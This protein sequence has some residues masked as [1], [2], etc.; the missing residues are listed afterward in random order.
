[1]RSE[2]PESSGP[3]HLSYPPQHLSLEELTP[4][5]PCGS[6]RLVHS[7]RR[8]SS[9]AQHGPLVAILS[10]CLVASW[11]VPKGAYRWPRSYSRYRLVI[12]L[13]RTDIY[14]IGLLSSQ[15]PDSHPT[16]HM[17]S[18]TNTYQTTMC[19]P[20]PPN[21]HVQT[22]FSSFHASRIVRSHTHASITQTPSHAVLY[23]TYVSVVSQNIV[24]S[25]VVNSCHLVLRTTIHRDC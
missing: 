1:M 15:V 18:V 19:C 14:F 16:F 22:P 5:R 8:T 4:V 10:S 23:L 25:I 12:S 11:T 7:V 6:R 13:K 24:S 3:S 20:F 2:H 9:P 21:L 17:L